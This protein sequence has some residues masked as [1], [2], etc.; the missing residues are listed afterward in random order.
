MLNVQSYGKN[1]KT[2]NIQ[3]LQLSINTEDNLAVW[4]RWA[5]EAVTALFLA[6][7]INVDSFLLV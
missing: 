6:Y 1:T 5:Y 7:I 3:S 2:I 4:S